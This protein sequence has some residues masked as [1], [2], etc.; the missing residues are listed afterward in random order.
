MEGEKQVPALFKSK[1]A[2]EDQFSMMKITTL[3][4]G[5]MIKS[6]FEKGLGATTIKVFPTQSS[7]KASADGQEVIKIEL[8]WKL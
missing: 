6:D 7:A 3:K 2:T 1:V 5:W 4:E 8:N